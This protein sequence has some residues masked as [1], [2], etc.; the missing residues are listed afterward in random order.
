MAG[1]THRIMFCGVRFQ[2][3]F[4]AD[5]QEPAVDEIVPVEKPLSPMQT[6]IIEPN[7]PWIISEANP[8]GASHAILLPVDTKTVQMDI[9]PI[10]HNLEHI[11]QLCKAD[12]AAHPHP[13][14]DQRADA[15]QHDTKLAGKYKVHRQ[16]EG[17]SPRQLILKSRFLPT[18]PPLFSA[19]LFNK[20]L[21]HPSSAANFPSRVWFEEAMLDQ[22]IWKEWLNPSLLGGELKGDLGRIQVQNGTSALTIT[23][24]WELRS[25]MSE[26]QYYEFLSIDRPLTAQ[27][28]DE[29]R[30]LS[31]RAQ[32]LHLYVLLP[33]TAW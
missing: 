17:G 25:I 3:A 29:L 6:E 12:I 21:Y 13:S 32:I 11:V 10:H 23:P 9:A 5:L 14:P 8:A 26:Y 15:A 18:H 1:C 7:L 31:T 27:E 16:V 19:L 30:D 4:Q 28:R 33:S 22:H 20:A 2:L 24:T